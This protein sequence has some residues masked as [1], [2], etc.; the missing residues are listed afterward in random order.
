MLEKPLKSQIKIKIC[1]KHITILHISHIWVLQMKM[2]NRS[3]QNRPSQPAQ[4]TCPR[5]TIPPD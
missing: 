1:S 2:E 3:Q 5:N 4:F